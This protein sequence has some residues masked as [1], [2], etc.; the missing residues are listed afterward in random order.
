MAHDTHPQAHI[1]AFWMLNPVSVVE[2]QLDWTNTAANGAVTGEAIYRFLYVTSIT[3]GA[4]DDVQE[5]M[6]VTLGTAAGG[7]DLGVCMARGYTNVSGTDVILI[8]VSGNSNRIG[9]LQLGNGTFF[10]T[11]W[12]D[13]RLWSKPPFYEDNGTQWLNGWVSEGVGGSNYNHLPVANGGPPVMGWIDTTSGVLS[14]DFDGSRSFATELTACLGAWSSNLAPAATITSSSEEGTDIDDNSVDGN[15]STRWQP[16]SPAGSWIKYVLG[17]AARVKK[18]VLTSYG[19]RSPQ[20]WKLEI[21]DAERGDSLG[22]DIVDQQYDQTAWDALEARTYYIDIDHNNEFWGTRDSD[23]HSE[24]KFTFS[25]GN[26]TTLGVNEM[27]LYAEDRSTAYTWDFADGTITTG[28]TTSE[29]PTVTFPPGFRWV[30][31]TVEDTNGYTD[32]H[33]VPVLALGITYTYA[34]GSETSYTGASFSA[35]SGVASRAFD[36]NTSTAWLTTTGADEWV[37]TTLAEAVYISAYKITAFGS[38][39]IYAP[40]DFELQ[41]YNGA[42]WVAADAQT[43]ETGWSP[44]EERQYDL[45]TPIEAA[46]WRLYVTANNGGASVGLRELDLLERGAV[47]VDDQELPLNAEVISRTHDVGGATLEVIMH[48]DISD[49][50]PGTLCMFGMREYFAGTEGATSEAEYDLVDRAFLKHWGWVD[51]EEPSH[52][53]TETGLITSTRLTVLDV[54]RRLAALPGWSMVQQRKYSPSYS[55]EMRRPTIDRLIWFIGKYLSNAVN[56]CDFFWSGTG[57]WYGLGVSSTYGADLYSMMDGRARSAG[58]FVGCNRLGQLRVRMNQNL[59]RDTLRDTTARLALTE[60]DYADI[61]WIYRKPPSY[62]THWGWAI[63]ADWPRYDY[64]NGSFDVKVTRSVAPGQVPVQGAQYSEQGEQVASTQ[65]NT[66]EIRHRTVL[67]FETQLTP[68]YGGM[69]FEMAAGN[70]VGFDPADMPPIT[71]TLGADYAA[72]RGDTWSE[73]VIYPVRI[74]QTYVNGE[75]YA[76]ANVE[77]EISQ[78]GYTG[79]IEP[80]PWVEV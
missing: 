63:S 55:Y 1:G 16:T 13:F 44:D 77:V 32:I 18:I 7:W 39:V 36:D 24:Y 8:W 17:S 11:V 51:T 6:T 43:G 73:Q 60:S 41:Y 25:S 57:A 61:R 58:M 19:T 42:T 37:S 31:L 46:Q 3:K 23:G 29:A 10:V 64:D 14:V 34:I 5:G 40:R 69:T 12:N 54:G 48:D 22:F 80:N 59:I 79:G 30:S 75:F 20:A 62:N 47:S 53:T 65:E 21:D 72:E 67:Q 15:T 71:I 26:G 2:A 76:D 52:D 68:V 74:T 56:V 28:T 38:F 66:T 45:A 9:D 35:S 4:V 50:P 78:T 27:E 49:Y 33:W 70:D